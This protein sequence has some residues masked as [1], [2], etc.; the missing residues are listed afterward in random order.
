MDP[1][2]R[3][4]LHN[5]GTYNHNTDYT[6][7]RTIRHNRGT[8]GHT[9]RLHRTD[10]TSR[11]IC[12]GYMP[13]NS[14]SMDCCTMDHN[15]CSSTMSFLCCMGYSKTMGQCC[16]SS[17]MD[18]SRHSRLC[19]PYPCHTKCWQTCLW[20]SSRCPFCLRKDICLRP[21]SSLPEHLSLPS[22]Q[23]FLPLI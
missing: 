14:S 8:K 4:N 11:S 20:G 3:T 7:L 19:C 22:T 15:A 18:Y 13:M 12:M 21:W 6:I 5:V 1:I 2:L 16:S 23:L 10:H 9:I 17:R